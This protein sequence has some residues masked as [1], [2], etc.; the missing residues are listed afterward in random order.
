MDLH[1]YLY[2]YMILYPL[3]TSVTT[4]LMYVSSNKIEMSAEQNSEILKVSLARPQS[5]QA[6]TVLLKFLPF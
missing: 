1:M 6:T 5:F 4:V 3:L 2:V